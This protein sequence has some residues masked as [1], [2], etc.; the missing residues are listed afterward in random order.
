MAEHAAA[1]DDLG[2]EQ[3]RGPRGRAS[4]TTWTAREDIK[5]LPAFSE[6]SSMH[7]CFVPRKKVLSRGERRHSFS[8]SAKTARPLPLKPPVKRLLPFD[9]CPL[10]DQKR[11][12]CRQNARSACQGRDQTPDERGPALPKGVGQPKRQPDK[13][14]PESQPTRI[15]PGENQR[16]SAGQPIALFGP[17][18]GPERSEPA[19]EGH[20]SGHIIAAISGHPAPE[21]QVEVFDA[22]GKKIGS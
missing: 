13:V 4:I 12:P 1:Q 15:L 5:R 18:L 2:R 3:P 10:P 6:I 21:S 9:P 11:P 20:R 16:I 22:P 8:R 14:I 7:R 19:V 17:D